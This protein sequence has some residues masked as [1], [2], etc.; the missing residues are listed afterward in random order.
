MKIAI[1]GRVLGQFAAGKTVYTESVLWQWKN[2]PEHTYHVYGFVPKVNDWPSNWSFTELASPLKR[3]TAF[4]HLKED[5]LFSPSS[6][7]TTIMANKP[8][9]TTVHDLVIYRSPVRLPLKTRLA[10]RYLL[11]AAVRRSAALTVQTESVARDLYHFFPTAQAKTRVITPGLSRTAQPETLP[12]ETTQTKILSEYGIRDDFILFVG[13]LEPRKNLTRLITAYRQ[14]PAEL[15]EKHQLVLAGKLGWADQALTEALRAVD[16]RQMIQTGRVEAEALAT[17]YHRATVV[18]YP[19]L[20]EGVGYPVLEAFAWAKPVITSNTS[21]LIEIG[22]NV[23]LLIDPTNVVAI[24][25]ALE[26]LLTNPIERARLAAL[27][28]ERAKQFSWAKTATAYLELLATL[29]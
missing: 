22:E 28:Q 3:L 8:T 6:Y 23:A 29:I 15:R 24:S 5:V 27:G 26:K 4:R 9:L 10:E 16:G 21:S 7:L 19:S 2:H 12:T 25:Q 17:F 11:G 1:D 13:T 20:Y 18:C 14:L